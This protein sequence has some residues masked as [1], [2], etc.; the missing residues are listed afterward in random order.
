MKTM[1]IYEPAMC[2]TTGLCGVGVDSELLRVS[3]VLEPAARVRPV[4]VGM[5]QVQKIAAVRIAK[6]DAA[7]IWK[8]V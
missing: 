6:K 1:K 2:C 3:T 7:S 5:K 8:G 4:A